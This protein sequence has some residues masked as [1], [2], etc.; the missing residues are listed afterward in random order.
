MTVSVITEDM[1]TPIS[2]AELAD[3]LAGGAQLI[4][5]RESHD[6]E[7]GHIGGSRGIPLETYRADP[8]AFLSRGTP[9]VFICA[10]GVR[11]LAAA[12]LAD[13]FGY[14]DL[15]SLEGGIKEWSALGYPVVIEARAAA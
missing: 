13:R 9:L 4:D 6:F 15:Y 12:K 5:V 10:K 14:E 2:P 7:A 8:D 11:S 3:L 1:V